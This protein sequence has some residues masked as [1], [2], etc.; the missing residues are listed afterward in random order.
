LLAFAPESTEFAFESRKINVLKIAI[1]G[2]G[3]ETRWILQGSLTGPW[4]REL[5]SC[6]KRRHRA[7]RARECVVDLNNV[8]FI[9][10]G[11]KRLL[12]GIF[13]N[14]AKFVANGIYTKHLLDTVTAKGKHR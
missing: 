2:T 3:T 14:G 4:V 9:D 7:E 10:E 1:T 12:R 13:K 5:R 6:W 8:T 11:G